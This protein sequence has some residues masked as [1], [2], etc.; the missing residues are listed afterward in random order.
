MAERNEQHD[1]RRG[2][3]PMLRRVLVRQLNRTVAI[4]VPTATYRWNH[5]SV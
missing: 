3:T 2:Q 4:V 1:R 5:D